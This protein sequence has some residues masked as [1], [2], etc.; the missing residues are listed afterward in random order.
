MQNTDSRDINLFIAY[1]FADLFLKKYVNYLLLNMFL[2]IYL[3]S[4]YN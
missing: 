2:F 1:K 3:Y 4:V